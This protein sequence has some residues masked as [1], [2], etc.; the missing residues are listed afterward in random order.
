MIVDIHAHIGHHPLMDFKQE[1]D[2]VLEVMDKFGLDKTFIHPFP[3]MKPSKVNEMVAKAVKKDP[4]RLVGFACIN[5][6]DDVCLTEIKKS[7]ELEL[8]GVM[9]DLE[10]HRV[11]RNFSKVEELMVL[12]MEHKLPVLLN[13]PNIE[14]GGSFILIEYFI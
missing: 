10:F 8:K 11:I 12:C 14:T 2:E 9:M 3:S 7:V 1:I 13:T 5:P 4:E 6:S